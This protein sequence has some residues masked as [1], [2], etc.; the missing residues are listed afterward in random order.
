MS[1]PRVDRFLATVFF[2]L[3][4]AGQVAGGTV[5]E[6]DVRHTF[7]GNALLLD[8]LRYENA[9]HETLSV[10]RLSYLLSGFALQ[11][12]DGTW[13]ELPDQFAWMDAAQRRAQMQFDDVPPGK[14]RALRFYFGPDAK[15]NAAGA[16]QFPP[17]N[18]LNPNLNGLYWSWQGGYIFLALEGLYRAG[19]SELKG[20]AYHLARNPNRTLINLTAD[21]DLMHDAGVSLDF[22]IAALLNAP[23][24]LSFEKDGM[25]THSRDG[26]PVA[27][28]LDTNLPAA[29][30][31]LGAGS[32]AP[33]ISLPSEVKPLYMPEKFTPYRF[34]MG[35]TFPVPDLPRDNP[36]IVER[37]T[38]GKKIFNDPALSHDGTVSCA[39]CHQAASAFAD[40]RPTTLGV[41]GQ[42]VA[43]HAMPLFNLAWKSNF[44]WDGRAPSLRAQVLFPIQ[45]HN[46]MDETLDRVAA[47]LAGNGDY[48]ALFRAAFGS[49]E[50]T[51]EKIG[52]ALENYL[53][54]ITSYN[55]KFDRALR[56]EEK[57]TAEEQRGLELFMTEN[58]PRTR[59]Y[60][61]DCFHCHGGALFTDH[62][63]HN[64][65]LAPSDADTGRFRITGLESD[66]GKFATPSLRNVALTAPYMHDGRFATLEQVV[67]HYNTGIVRSP[68]LDPNLAKHPDG[69]LHLSPADC[70][71]LVAFLKTL[72][73]T[74]AP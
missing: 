23:H 12:E 50:I 26:D 70:R 8:S 24:A 66:R 40:P 71:A 65:G 67:E 2:A 13:V 54:T 18:P 17:G 31:V 56:G 34:L 63:F 44:F 45:A 43:R 69:G 48:P 11:R 9:A 21:I 61:A 7:N 6:I 59:Q 60:G 4:F 38:L 22:D 49:P 37:V 3:I 58:D 46:E 72:T 25:S 62:Q 74:P 42:A 57:F 52:L 73:D 47:K 28:A 41:R 16:A 36:L 27:A 64:D 29:F 20:Y 14:Y 39:S 51:M 55:A 1:M 33:A 15:T 30:R 19:G 10:T 35:A 32:V 5:L 68:T 53:L